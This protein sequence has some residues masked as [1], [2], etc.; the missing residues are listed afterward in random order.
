MQEKSLLKRGE[1]V[2]ASDIVGKV[3]NTGTASTG[4]H[5]H[6]S[7][8]TEI[9]N[10]KSWY[11]KS[12][13]SMLFGQSGLNDSMTNNTGTKTVFNPSEL[14]EN[15]KNTGKNQNRQK[16]DSNIIKIIDY[17]NTIIK[18]KKMNR[19]VESFLANGR[20]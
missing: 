10:G 1:R 6:Y 7:I 11:S 5:L 13:A 17:A 20:L 14:Y 3:G 15:S 19:R 4:P 18:K 8:F 9:K 12:V 2:S 16:K